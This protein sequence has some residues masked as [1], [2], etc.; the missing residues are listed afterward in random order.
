MSD[1]PI[2]TT[3]GK[4]CFWQRLLRPQP[5]QTGAAPSTSYLAYPNAANPRWFL[6]AKSKLR[7]SGIDIFCPQSLKGKILKT[8]VASGVIRG[9]SAPAAGSIL[10]NLAN[11]ISAELGEE[12]AHLAISVGTPG[13]YR[14]YT[15]RIMSA[16]GELLAYG[17]LADQKPAISKLEAEKQALEILGS[18]KQLHISV[19]NL[20][21]FLEWEDTKIMLMEAG[22]EAPAFNRLTPR[23]LDF[24]SRLFLATYQEDNFFNGAM[25]ARMLLRSELVA[26]KG[27]ETWKS[28]VRQ[29]IDVLQIK[30]RDLIMPLSFAHGDFVPWNTSMGPQGL[31]VFDWEAACFG[32]PPLYDAFHF[33]AMQQA[34]KDRPYQP[35]INFFQKQLDKASPNIKINVRTLFLAYLIDIALF[36]CS[37]RIESPD[38]GDGRVLNWL[39]QNLDLWRHKNGG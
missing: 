27:S 37:A 11:R 12:N 30:W 14:K 34:L 2:T 18:Y 19:P 32:A 7:Q 21:S 23:H 35:D 26:A 5:G 29:G 13:A 25:W 10:A 36:Y 31:Y 15:L 22:P 9:A 39:G 1:F 20:I 24:L 17:K 8:L 4:D 38:R 16:D 6:P 3:K 33:Q 28:R